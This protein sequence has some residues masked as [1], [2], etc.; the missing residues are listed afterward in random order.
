MEWIFYA[1]ILATALVLFKKANQKESTR[2]T[3][4]APT[5]K[6]SQPNAQAPER[7]TQQSEKPNRWNDGFKYAPDEAW[8]FAKRRL[9]TDTEMVLFERLKEALPEHYIFTQVQLSQMVSIK[10]G[11]SFQRWF[12]RISRMS[13]DFVVTDK[14]LNTIAAIELDDKTHYLDEQRQAADAKKDKVLTAAGIR[15]I[16]WRCEVMPSKDQI[17]LAFPEA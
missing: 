10:K 2:S 11:H 8:P 14:N 16:R 6:K 1:L 7:R 13:V 5:L 4:D 15:V 12:A 3:W 17:A 9:I